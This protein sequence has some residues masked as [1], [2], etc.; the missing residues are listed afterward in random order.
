MASAD[1]SGLDRMKQSGGFHGKIPAAIFDSAPLIYYQASIKGRGDLTFI[2]PNAAEL[3]KYDTNVFA[4]GVATLKALIHPKDI[5]TYLKAVTESPQNSYSTIEYRIRDGNGSYRWFSDRITLLDKS[6]G[7]YSGW[8][9]DI[10]AERAAR[11]QREIERQ[12][13]RDLQQNHRDVVES[14][15]SGFVLTN[16][17]DVVIAINSALASVAGHDREYFIGHP[18]RRL[19][20]AMAPKMDIFDGTPVQDTDEWIDEFTRTM[21]GLTG[22]SVEIRMKAGEWIMVTLGRTSSGGQA[23]VSFDISQRKHIE[24]EL[25][26][27]EEHFRT[28]VEN[29]PLPAIL[30]DFETGRV[31]YESPSASRM[32]GREEKTEVPFHVQELYADPSRR[33]EFM[34]ALKQHGELTDYPIH[35]RRPDGS[36]YWISCNSKLINIDGRDMHIT[37]ITN[38]SEQQERESALKHANETL[39]DAIES[40]SEGFALY[41]KDNRL[42]TFNSRY[43]EYNE[44][45]S[46][47]LQPGMLFE[48]LIRTGA[49]R[50]EYFADEEEV[51]LFLRS[52]FDINGNRQTVQNF[53]FQQRTH[54]RWLLYS[55]YVTRQNGFVVTLNDVTT[56]KAM[57]KALR[58]SEEEI[59]QVLEASPTPI[60]VSNGEDSVILYES[61]M[62][63]ELFQ[64]NTKVGT[65][66]AR[67]YWADP[68]QRD[69]AWQKLKRDGEILDQEVLF[70]K[71]DGTEFWASY[72]ARVLS[73]RSNSMIVSTVHDLTDIKN[74]QEE[75]ARQREVLHVSEKMIAMGEL[76]AS[77]SHELN[78][79][80]SVVV[81]QTLL[82]R[83]TA[84]DPAVIK[85]AERIS[86]AADRCARIVKTFLAMARQQPLAREATDL[87]NLIDL[88]LELTA[89]SLRGSNVEIV[90]KKSS[91]L[92]TAL[93]DADQIS[94]V[95]TNLIVNAEHAM[96]QVDRD[97][98]LTISTRYDGSN[99]EVVVKVKDNGSGIPGHLRRRIFEPFVTTKKKDEGTGIGLAL[100][101]RLVDANGGRIKLESRPGLGTTFTI[102]LPANCSG[103][104]ETLAAESSAST[105]NSLTVLIVDDEPEVAE[106]IADILHLDGHSAV[107]ANNGRV[108]FM[109]VKNHDF[110]IILSDLRMPDFDGP[111]LYREIEKFKPE[112]LSRLAF[113]TGDTLSQEIAKFLRNSERPYIEKPITPTDV[114]S[115][116]S[117]LGPSASHS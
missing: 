41:D 61:P 38:L 103:E 53:E 98:R 71:G 87:N 85:R 99:E 11:Y 82:L 16:K 5:G 9:L 88:S 101:H 114:R 63:K 59:R 79:P 74:L 110:H 54:S 89:Y 39:E 105:N 112:L 42:I 44:T 26:K 15:I 60:T 73:Y 32:F 94:Q 116:I 4:D 108:G 23:T 106:L 1:M 34:S 62:S 91:S 95:L 102:R 45:C 13:L 93:V 68:R 8:M 2:S 43:Q 10:D 19:F 75:M 104:E 28:L 48:D 96:R 100:C 67:D 113:I 33:K 24:D 25:R 40:L 58:E 3:L 14:L 49:N 37:S 55:C 17:N 109:H 56:S 65:I 7:V 36:T 21:A 46:D 35:Y 117:V 84:D 22:K 47:I 97:R 78:N 115:L 31:V 86:N 12:A 57:A 30:V 83:E 90:V 70:R 72:S 80:L 51:S 107:I 64:R 20:E 69:I 76:L 18:R 81:G 77:V 52:H 27:S 29:Q 6:T 111:W 50:E 66:R 92:P